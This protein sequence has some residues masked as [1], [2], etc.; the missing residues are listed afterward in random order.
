MLLLVTQVSLRDLVQLLVRR[1]A[2]LLLVTQVSLLVLV[3][4]LARRL[5]MPLLV[6]QVNSLPSL[7]L[8]SVP[9]RKPLRFLSSLRLTQFQ[10]QVAAHRSLSQPQR[11]T[12]LRRVMVYGR[13]LRRLF[14][15]VLALLRGGPRSR[16]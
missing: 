10:V 6:T 7:R 5:E 2:T 14:L 13:L 15:P 16:S 8:V 9:L 11:F 12:V 1:L 3:L 4:A